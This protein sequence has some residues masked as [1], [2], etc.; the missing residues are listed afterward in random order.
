[1]SEVTASRKNGRST[2]RKPQARTLELHRQIAEVAGLYR[3]MTVRQ[4]Y[5]QLVN[6]GLPKTEAAYDRV[7]EA[8]VQMRLAGTLPYGKIADGSRTR[9]GVRSYSS[10]GEALADTE[11]YY[12]R[13]YWRDM[14][15]R[16]EVWCEKDAL[17]GVIQPICAEYGVTYVATRGFPSVTLVYESA[18]WMRYYND[19]RA[20]GQT[21]KLYYFGDHDASGRSI[22]DGLPE[23]LWAHGA[24]V[25]VVR[26]ALEPEQVKA[27]RLPTR[28]NKKSDTRRRA[29]AAL[30]GDES[31]EL[32]ALPP[33]ELERL[34]RECITENIDRTTWNMLAVA[35]ESERETLGNLA[36]KYSDDTP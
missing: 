29:F 22:S 12:R 17:T 28:P 25:E 21:T 7:Q 5:Y 2:V 35:E 15:A 14:P 32:D 3:Q 23:R 1:M 10:L 34:V 19:I 6:R 33:G 16:V 30:Y 31:V 9:T 24:P 4:L 27:H 13:D 11:S 18:M 20:S 26:K 8:T 36:L